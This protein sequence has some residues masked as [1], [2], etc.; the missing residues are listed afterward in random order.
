MGSDE[1]D[2]GFTFTLMSILT[3]QFGVI[4]HNDFSKRSSFDYSAFQ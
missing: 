1:W 2:T 4:I 3:E